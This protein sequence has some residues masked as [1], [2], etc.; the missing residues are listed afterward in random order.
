MKITS[1]VHK[2]G[3]DLIMWDYN[4][5]QWKVHQKS[6]EKWVNLHFNRREYTHSTKVEIKNYVPTEYST[7]DRRFIIN[8]RY[9]RN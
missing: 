6:E 5:A 7:T 3:K 1:F 9:F 2:D 4:L 8:G